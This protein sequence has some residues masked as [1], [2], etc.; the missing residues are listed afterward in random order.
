MGRLGYI[1]IAGAGALLLAAGDAAAQTYPERPVRI[2]VPFPPGGL[3]DTVARLIQPFLENSLGQ[4]VIVDNRPAASGIVGTEA[5]AKAAPDGTALLMVASS[6][7]V[8]PATNSKLPYDAERDLQ[9]I[10]MVGTNPLLFLVNAKVPATSLGQFVALAKASP[11][12]FNYASTGAASQSHLVIELFSRAAGIKL[13]HVPYR[14]GAPAIMATVAGETAFTVVSLLAS[15]SQIEAGNLRALATGSLARD[16]QF[17]DLPTVAESG[18]PGFTAIQ[19][20]GLLTTAGTPTPIVERLNAEVN[21]ALR[22]PGL[23]AK[24]AAQGITPAGGSPESFQATI[25]NEIRKW[26]EVAR[27][28]GITAE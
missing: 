27:A 21:R 13:Q 14:G 26:T 18:F 3:N 24:L 25:A 20:V 19:W 7:T 12:I 10:V 6:Y 22:D 23:A 5:V 16:P 1:L 2:I 15:L 11:G 17:P 8:I 28:A 4:P 9:P